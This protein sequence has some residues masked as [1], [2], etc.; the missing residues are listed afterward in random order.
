MDI[1]VNLNLL[2]I[3]HVSSSNGLRDTLIYSFKKSKKF[4]PLFVF[5][6]SDF[7]KN[8]SEHMYIRASHCILVDF[9]VSSPSRRE[10]ISCTIFV[11]LS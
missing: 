8:Y 10:K 7:L 11:K 3:F 9:Y 6:N 2:I 4:D 5:L 1:H